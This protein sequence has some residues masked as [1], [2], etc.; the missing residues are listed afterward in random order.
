MLNAQGR[1]REGAGQGPGQ[2]WEVVGAPSAPRR[3]SPHSTP[4]PGA[5]SLPVTGHP[6]SPGSPGKEGTYCAGCLLVTWK[7][8][9]TEEV[10][11][12]PVPPSHP[13]GSTQPA[14]QHPPHYVPHRHPAWRGGKELRMPLRAAALLSPL[15][16]AEPSRPPLLHL[17]CSPDEAG[18]Q[19]LQ[20]SVQ[21]A[22]EKGQRSSV[23]PLGRPNICGKKRGSLS[24]PMCH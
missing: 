20:Q 17:P 21:Q 9:N 15:T 2:P 1:S 3:A 23:S 7:R 19:V 5:A 8:E 22:N 4:S 24:T 13:H 10:R 14:P 11:P 12:G 6:V 18:T 16:A